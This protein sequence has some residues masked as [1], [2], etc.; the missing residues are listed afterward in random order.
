MWLKLT[1]NNNPPPPLVLVSKTRRNAYIAY[2]LSNIRFF[3]VLVFHLLSFNYFF[4]VLM[5]LFKFYFI[6]K[7]CMYKSF[8]PLYLFIQD[9]TSIYFTNAIWAS[10]S[11]YT[12]VC[13]LKI[14]LNISV[15][16][17]VVQRK[18]ITFWSCMKV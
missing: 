14:A 5:M 17:C 2:I 6:N 8:Y 4:C 3:H 7:V 16:S 13:P 12:Q 9:K 1:S 10:C 18:R 11:L 15:K